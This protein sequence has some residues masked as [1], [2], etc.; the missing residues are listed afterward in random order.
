MPENWSEFGLWFVTAFL[1][2]GLVK[3]IDLAAS[4]YTDRQANTKQQV[5]KLLDYIKDYGQLTELFRFYA[6]YSAKIVKDE[7][8]EFKKDEQG[9]FVMDRRIL[10]PDPRFEG[11]LKALQ[12]TD[13]NSAITQKI[14]ALRLSSAEVNDIAYELDPS[15]KLNEGFVNLYKLTV[16][17]IELILHDRNTGN[18]DT[19]FTEMVDALKKADECRRDLRKQVQSFAK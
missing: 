16:W 9:K 13:I 6:Y 7:N 8:G 14:A 18:L 17:S 5:E 10:E 2:A 15:D 1:G 4:R 19:K 3:L 11:A 12:G